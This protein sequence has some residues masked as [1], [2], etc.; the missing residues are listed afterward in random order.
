MNSDDE[1]R[2]SAEGV[3][4]P[5][6]AAPSRIENDDAESGK[7]TMEQWIRQAGCQTG[8]EC[9][10]SGRQAGK[11][12][13]KHLRQFLRPEEPIETDRTGFGADEAAAFEFRR[14]FPL[15]VC[16]LGFG[17]FLS[18]LCP[19]DWYIHA[20]SKWQI[21]PLGALSLYGSIRAVRHFIRPL[22]AQW[23]P[24]I[25]ICLITATVGIL[26]LGLVQS[27]VLPTGNWTS[28]AKSAV[29]GNKTETMINLGVLFV[30]WSYGR[31]YDP[32]ASVVSKFIG[33]ICGVGFC[34]ETTKLLPLFLIIVFRK[35]LPFKI[36]LSFRSFLMLGFFSGLGF[37][38][39]E[40]L[41]SSY[42]L[43][44]SPGPM[45]QYNQAMA[46]LWY[47]EQMEWLSNSSLS[48]QIGR[49]FACVPSH[50]LYT[51]VDAAFL[52]MLHSRIACE[53]EPRIKFAWFAACVATI[54]VLHGIYDVLCGIPYMG[55]LM[56]AASLVV[57][58]WCVRLAARTKNTEGNGTGVTLGDFEPVSVRTFGKS[59][60]KTYLLMFVGILLYA[61]ELCR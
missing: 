16:C 26:L 42:C 19:N 35:K 25:S 38:I 30:K 52:W 29:G 50:A 10:R 23:V 8:R 13:W 5:D 12:F 41:S 47:Q 51:V 43:V 49:W 32:D 34:E 45:P 46:T 6:Y 39:G 31:V 18:A 22:T 3:S 15:A 4:V 2:H 33:Y 11:L 61:F 57:L 54:A 48:G 60:G 17:W 53:Q 56:D 59:F 44:P 20:I 58:W 21:L 1:I 14:L 36:D 37:G 55:F 40:A 9:I 28:V 7:P 24:W 27:W